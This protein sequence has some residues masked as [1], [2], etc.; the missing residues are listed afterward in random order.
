MEVFMLKNMLLFLFVVCVFGCIN[1]YEPESFVDN[2]LTQL[3]TFSLFNYAI[4]SNDSLLLKSKISGGYDIKSN[5]HLII[6]SRVNCVCNAFSTIKIFVGSTSYLLGNAT[7]P[8]IQYIQGHIIGTITHADVPLVIFP[9]IDTLSFYNVALFNNQIYPS[10]YIFDVPNSVYTIPGGIMYITGDI[11]VNINRTYTN[12][13]IIGC[14]VA[15]GNINIGVTPYGIGRLSCSKTS[16]TDVILMSINGSITWKSIGTDT[17][18]G[19]IYVCNGDYIRN[20]QNTTY[21]TGQ[22]LVNGKFKSAY[23][24]YRLTYQKMYP[25]IN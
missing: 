19:L 11:T 13:Q 24:D 15:S 8:T 22:I 2:K 18:N 21:L 20:T 12:S 4:C 17:H 16:V 10:G 25:V 1:V 7:A 9:T 5:N 3:D 6:D 23:T 14:I